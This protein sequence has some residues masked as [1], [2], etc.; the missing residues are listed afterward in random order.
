[1]LIHN[2]SELQTRMDGNGFNTETMF[3][4]PSDPKF[5]KNSP[6]YIGPNKR[7]GE[8]KDDELNRFRLNQ[9]F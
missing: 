5:K 3:Y 7:K 2:T 6:T 4:D 9:S 8:T 1:M